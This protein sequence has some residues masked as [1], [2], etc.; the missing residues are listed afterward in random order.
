MKQYSNRKESMQE[1]LVNDEEKEMSEISNI[2]DGLD[3][4]KKDKEKIIAYIQKEEFRGHLPHP[5]LLRQYNEV[6]PG[7]ADK[8]MH[9][10]M[11]EQNHRHELE[12][13]IVKSEISLN[14]GQLDIISASIKMKK[15][16]QLF[17]FLLTF[18]LVI[19]GTICI[20]INKN[21]GS[22]IPFILAIGSFVW[23]MF[24]GK[25]T[26]DDENYEDKQHDESLLEK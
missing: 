19:V 10:A 14:D 7:F 9:M 2:I 22:I 8:I 4:D 23:T 11:Q 12:S 26:P 5:E 18:F 21:I 24:Y 1:N 15:R 16:L 25:K 20:F 17:S 3:I 13:R 6:S